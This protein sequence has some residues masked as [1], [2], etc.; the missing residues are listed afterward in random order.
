MANKEASGELIPQRE[1]D[2]FIIVFVVLS[3]VLPVMIICL[4][5]FFQPY[6]LSSKSFF[7]LFCGA[8]AHKF[9]G[10]SWSYEAAMTWWRA[11]LWPHVA[12]VFYGVVIFSGIIALWLAEFASRP[13]AKIRHIL[14]SRFYGFYEGSRKAEKAVVK[15]LKGEIKFSGKGL[16][17]H[18]SV[19][20]SRDR[21]T[22]HFLI[23]GS[24]GGGKTTIIIPMVKQIQERGDIIIIFDNKGE[25]TGL[26]PGVIMA[27]WDDRCIGWAVGADIVNKQDAETLAARLIH[28]N[29]NEPMWAQGAQMIL[30]AFIVKAQQE[31]SKKWDF[32]DII[33]DLKS[34]DSNRIKQ[35]V[36]VH[37][38]LASMLVADPGSKTTLS[39]LVQVMACMAPVA[40]LAEAW[41]GRDKVSFRRWLTG[42]IRAGKDNTIILQSNSRYSETTKAY[43]HSIIQT[44]ASI[45]NSPELS[46]SRDRRIWLILD[47]VPQLGEMVELSEFLEIG[48]SKGCCVILG[49]QSISQVKEIYSDNV[50]D[51]WLSMIGTTI[52]C[53]TQGKDSPRWLSELIGNRKIEKLTV[54]TSFSD[55]PAGGGNAQQFTKNYSYQEKD[56]PVVPSQI[57]SS[58]KEL[59]PWNNKGLRAI[60]HTNTDVVCRLIWPFEK[61]SKI[62]PAVV[63]RKESAKLEEAIR[64]VSNRDSEGASQQENAGPNEGKKG[65]VKT[66]SVLDELAELT[67]F[68]DDDQEG[69]K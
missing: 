58:S 24:T 16:N 62:R 51:S 8:G 26:L 55:T 34:S 53:R 39:F 38:P 59:G 25:F 14:G 63:A 13:P 44:L 3:V 18:P 29:G 32:L 27:P 15:A 46:N 47:E 9:V 61:H 33:N 23:I 56:E 28:E 22:R 64:C 57:I 7:M 45:I 19:S 42:N 41:K 69:R 12:Y 49:V 17:I 5:G 40:A 68:S 31:K 36:D 21:E 43:L 1:L 50:A 37:N 54:S 2:Y 6:G 10:T 60:L 30:V 11:G 4:A 35:V 20:I 48:R 66:M 67:G 65:K 52:L